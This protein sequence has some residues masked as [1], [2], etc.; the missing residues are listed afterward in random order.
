MPRVRSKQKRRT[1]VAN[2]ATQRDFTLTT[3]DWQDSNAQDGLTSDIVFAPGETTKSLRFTIRGDNKFDGSRALVW[4][5]E[6]DANFGFSQETYVF[7][8]VLAGNPDDNPGSATNPSE[9]FIN[10]VPQSIAL[11]LNSPFKSTTIIIEEDQFPERVIRGTANADIFYVPNQNFVNA[12]NRLPAFKYGY[13]VYGYGGNDT[14][15]GAD[16]IDDLYG[17]EGNDALYGGN[18]SDYLSGGSGNDALYG[19][20]EGVNSTDPGDD[21]LDGGAG[22]DRLFGGAGADV[23]Y[24]W[25]GNDILIGG[26]A[27]ESGADILY[28][29]LGIDTLY[30]SGG[31]DI[32]EGGADGDRFEFYNPDTD[33]SDFVTDFDPAEDKIGLY[34]ATQTTPIYRRAGLLFGSNQT[35][36]PSQFV[37]VDTLNEAQVKAKD[38]SDRLLYNRRSG[39]LYFDRDGTGSA[40]KQL[41]VTL[42]DPAVAAP[43]AFPGL[44]AAN[45]VRFG[46]LEGK[47]LVAKPKGANLTGTNRDDWLI[48]KTGNDRF[49]GAGGNDILN[50]GAGKDSLEGGKGDD[51]LYGGGGQDTLLGGS[52]VDVFA[53]QKGAGVVTIAD[54][55]KGQDRLG[56]LSGIPLNRLTFEQ[57]GNQTLISLKND[58]LAWL[59]GIKPNQISR[60]SIIPIAPP[61][62]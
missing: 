57:Q 5:I 42:A 9:R 11:K 16:G 48:G 60:A 15:W 58:P 18:S 33:G 45:I 26:N 17:W 19:E 13:A 6:E 10:S 59:Q 40:A 2:A 32:L 34:L 29:E 46:G 50:G 24:G 62:V 51:T 39:K 31:N 27:S 20:N 38:A 28:G 43:G 53:L 14:I 3:P 23:L 37:A 47:R 4:T 22:D 7:N 56:L 1:A 61:L 35:L 8:E 41:I 21:L 55:K 36:A 25:A 12:E 54:F 44:S 52:G 30:G 49:N